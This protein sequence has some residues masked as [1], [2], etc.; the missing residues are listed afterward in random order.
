[1]YVHALHAFLGIPT[2]HGIHMGSLISN[3]KHGSCD[4]HTKFAFIRQDAED[5]TTCNVSSMGRALLLLKYLHHLA[6]EHRHPD[7][8]MDCMQKNT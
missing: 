4:A 8:P 7:D 3:F 2:L 1:M 6:Y 5:V